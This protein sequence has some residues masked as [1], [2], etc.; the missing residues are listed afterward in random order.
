ML[1]PGRDAFQMLFIVVARPPGNAGGALRKV[2]HM[3]AGAAAGLQH[4]AGLASQE[5]RKHRPDRLVIAVVGSG[6]E[7]P[8]GLLWPP[9]LAEFDHIFRHDKLP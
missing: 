1:A 5:S 2:H 9:I 7:P 6:I 3:L 8:I 4:V